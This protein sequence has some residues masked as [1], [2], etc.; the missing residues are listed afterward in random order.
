MYD[1]AF[2]KYSLGK[3]CDR[4]RNSFAVLLLLQMSALREI[5]LAKEIHDAGV[6]GHQYLYLGLSL[7]RSKIPITN[8]NIFNRL[9]HPYLPKD[10]IQRRILPFVPLGSRTSQIFHPFLC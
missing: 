1:P 4:F 7:P 3:V 8:A 10:E 6:D 2:E 5:S 9:L